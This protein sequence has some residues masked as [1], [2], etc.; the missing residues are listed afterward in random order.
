[1]LTNWAKPGSPARGLL[2]VLSGPAGVGK[3]TLIE[4]WQLVAPN[5]RRLVTYTTRPQAINERHGLDYY[6]VTEA[7]F[8]ALR[9]E[10]AFLEYAEVHGNWYGT[11]RREM[12]S[13]RDAGRDVVLRIDVQG[14]M[15]VRQQF[16]EAILIF[17][18]PPSLQELEQRLRRRGRD[19][20]EAIQLRLMNA[21]AEME[22]IPQ[23]DYLIINDDLNRALETLRCILIA[24]RHRVRNLSPQALQE[25]ERR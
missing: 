16:P 3:D 25:V 19:D 8:H 2:I 22:Y 7:E 23:Y 1:M 10:G 15:Q 14:A 13:L 6:F 24:E 21:R 12:E 17:V 18:A 5:V 20:E 9:E 11:P 4:Q